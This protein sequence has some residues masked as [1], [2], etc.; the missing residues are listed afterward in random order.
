MNIEYQ[1]VE[2]NFGNLISL[3]NKSFISKEIDEI[4]DFVDYGEYGLALD[5]L[6]D[7]IKEENKEINNGIFQ[8][9]AELSNLMEQNM[10]VITKDLIKYINFD[11]GV[12]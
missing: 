2:E 8:Y 3:L 6:I 7:I 12:E 11:M 4:K 5:T 10:E 1:D 9:I